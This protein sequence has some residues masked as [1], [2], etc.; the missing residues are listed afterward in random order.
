MRHQA[1]AS[2]DKGFPLSSPDMHTLRGWLTGKQVGR[3]AAV[4]LAGTLGPPCL[5]EGIPASILVLIP[6]DQ[7]INRKQ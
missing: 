5:D 6:E 7:G 1:E 4:I 2:A 3:E